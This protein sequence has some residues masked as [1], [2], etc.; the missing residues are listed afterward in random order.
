MAPEPRP[1]RVRQAA[2]ALAWTA[3]VACSPAPTEEAPDRQVA[4]HRARVGEGVGETD[5]VDGAPAEK[6]AVGFPD[7]AQARRLRHVNRSGSPEKGTILE[8]NGAGVA[9]LDLGNDGDL[10]VVFTQGL[11]SLDAL[12]NGSGADLCVWSNDGTGA[13]QPGQNPRLHGWWTGLA[14][15][16]VDGDGYA[17]LVA[18]GFGNLC[19]VRQR[20]LGRHSL[21]PLPSN[22]LIGPDERYVPG[23][24]PSSGPP[25]WATSLALFDADRDGALDLYVGRYVELD[26]EALPRSELGEG[27]LAVPCEWKGLAVFCGPRGLKAQRDSLFRGRGDGTFE[28]L[29]ESWL[30]EETA[31]YTLGVA[32]FDADLDGDTDLFVANDSMPNRLWIQ[33]RAADGGVRFED[34]ALSAGVA[35]NP[36]GLAEAGMGVAVGDVNRDGRPDFAVT[37]FSD[38]PTQLYVGAERGFENASYRLGLASKTRRLLSWGVHLEDFDGDGWLELVTAN[39]HVY[40]QADQPG[41]GT[42]YGQRDT[43]FRLHPAAQ[44]VELEEP[45]IFDARTGTRGSAVGDVD[46]DGAPDLVLARLDGPAAL[47]INRLNPNANRLEIRCLGPLEA[48]ADAPRTAARRNRH[49]GRRRAREPRP[50]ARSANRFRLPISVESLAALRA[51]SVDRGA[52]DPDPL[53]FGCG[54]RTGRNPRQPQVG[55]ARGRRS[56]V[57]RRV[58]AL[59]RSSPRVVASGTI[60]H[61]LLPI[62]LVLAQGSGEETAPQRSQLLRLA[63]MGRSAEIVERFAA[64]IE[65]GG[66][67]AN[68]GQLVALIAAAAFDSGSEQRASDWLEGARPTADTVVFVDLERVR[69]HMES[70]RLDGALSALT[71]NVTDAEGRTRSALRH[72]E[73]A[74]SWLLLAR[75]RAR[76]EH[77][78]EARPAAERYLALSPRGEG[79]ATAWHIVARGLLDAGNADEARAAFERSRELERW[80]QLFRVRR[81]QALRAP[82]DPLPRLGL[83]L[84]WREADDLP[85]ATRELEGL[86]SDFPAFA[87][88]HFHLAEAKRAAGEHED[89]VQSYERALG[90]DAAF[91]AARLNRAQLLLTLGRNDAAESEFLALLQGPASEVPELLPAHLGLARALLARGAKDAAN[92][93][94]ERYRALGGTEALDPEGE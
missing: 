2:R 9:L 3:L 38:E 77:W 53:A 46:G 52:R 82:E 68:D 71:R 5:G 67:W 48:S 16:D 75:I 74:A 18:G 47:G 14:S 1:R 54:G 78:N 43:L 65:A 21:T 40:P 73:A 63:E 13:F 37:N 24:V 23:A 94:Y 81:L 6:R 32:P 92:E 56:R 51:G 91:V 76:Q 80:L 85:R 12:L 72:P 22:D 7:E 61:V 19:A 86:V 17:D 59:R 15:G 79:A 11:A 60:A 8:A 84:L 10:D 55:R 29:T 35:L 20:S 49:A 62:L 28:D 41:T 64:S 57:G 31:A 50:D 39:G 69:Q 34:R 89:A 4:E 83:A 58:V 25:S 42:S 87:R 30:P 44:L 70:D 36:D 88:G 26:P 27:A 33:G 45:S 90:L 66:P 93:R